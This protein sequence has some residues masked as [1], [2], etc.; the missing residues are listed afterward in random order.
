M[1]PVSIDLEAEKKE[2]LK[3]Y[4]ALLRTLG[5]KADKKDNPLKNAPHTQ[6]TVM[7]DQWPHSYSRQEAA[8]PLYY[9]TH[10]KFWPSVSR[11]NN[12]HGD[13]NLVCTCEPV[14]SY[15]QEN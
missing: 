9:V 7:A 10:N 8:Y 11:V 3:R 1:V 12:T 14:S 6:Q 4:S 13:R 5:E 15:L 2:I